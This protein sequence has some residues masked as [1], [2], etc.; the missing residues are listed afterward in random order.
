MELMNERTSAY[1]A[2]DWAHQA[3]NCQM[4]RQPQPCREG[5]LLTLRVDMILQTDNSEKLM[6]WLSLTSDCPWAG[7]L[8]R[9]AIEKVHRRHRRVV[10]SVSYHT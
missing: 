6:T 4:T 5:C 8:V 3:E 9:Y 2:T 10:A 7:S 1:E